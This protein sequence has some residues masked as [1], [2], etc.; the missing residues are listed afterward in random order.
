MHV[1]RRHESFG[2]IQALLKRRAGGARACAFGRVRAPAR[3]R[4]RAAQSARHM[5][6]GFSARTVHT[7]CSAKNENK[8]QTHTTI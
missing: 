8:G 3:P 6:G 1:V 5:L 7:T 4:R 2:F